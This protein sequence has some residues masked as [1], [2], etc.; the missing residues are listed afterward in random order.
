MKFISLLIALLII[1]FLVKKQLDSSSSNTEYEEI[2][3]NKTITVPKVPTAPKD[4]QKFEKDI[5]KFMLEATDQ[6][7]KEMEESLNNE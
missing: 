5:N 2:I 6:R 1:G 3:G 4:V 7:E